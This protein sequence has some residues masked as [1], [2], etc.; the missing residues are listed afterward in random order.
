MNVDEGNVNLVSAQH[1][2]AWR[3]TPAFYRTMS[4]KQAAT[5]EQEQYDAVM[6]CLYNT[7]L[8]FG[9]SWALGDYWI[10]DSAVDVTGALCVSRFGAKKQTLFI[11]ISVIRFESETLESQPWNVSSVVSRQ[12]SVISHGVIQCT[13]AFQSSI[14]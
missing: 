7:V 4:W 11:C 9:F 10:W 3:E 6:Q 5:T 12:S 8:L 14:Q 2:D 1:G 13:T